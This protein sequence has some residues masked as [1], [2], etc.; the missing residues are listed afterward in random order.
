MLFLLIRTNS[1]LFLLNIRYIFFH[2][3]GSNEPNYT[4]IT[5]GGG[6]LP[7]E[8]GRLAD[9]AG[10]EKSAKPPMRSE[11]PPGCK[12]TQIQMKIKR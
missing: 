4:K 6:S 8:V 11:L 1:C 2:Q 12:H 10:E 5:E 3:S 9:A 7:V